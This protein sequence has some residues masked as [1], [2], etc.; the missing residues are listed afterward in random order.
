VIETD[1]AEIDWDTVVEATY[2]VRQRFRYDY[3]GPIAS[4]NH[5][6]VVVPRDGHADQRRIA[7]TL[8]INPEAPPGAVVRE[9]HDAF[10]NAVVLVLA[11]RVEH[12][13]EFDFRSIV[14]RRAAPLHRVC[15]DALR[16]GA[17]QGPTDLTRTDAALDDA[18]RDLLVR[19]HDPFELADALNAFVFGH[20]RYAHGLTDV[21]TPAARAFEL[22]RG[23]CQDYAHVMLALAR[24]CGIAARYVS[25]HLLGEGGTH[26]WVELIVPAGNE[27][28]VL[29][30]DPTHGR[31]VTMKYVVVA[32]G[33]DYADV[34]PTS[35]S[36]VAPYGGE[37]STKKCVDVVR[38]RHGVKGR[39]AS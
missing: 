2:V 29:A 7:H 36:F 15:G 9:F 34:A 27:A 6:L 22:G 1:V 18:A 20:M 17:L 19:H 33:R 38:L 14:R 12:F 21:S 4:L 25:G 24:R 37:L 8:S 26:A 39:A 10:G 32:V 23:V 28:V 31:H 11:P 35:G 13:I 3:P 30:F 16:A 5:R